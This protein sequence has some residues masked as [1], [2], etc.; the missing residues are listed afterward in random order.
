MIHKPLF[1]YNSSPSLFNE[2]TVKTDDIICSTKFPAFWIWLIA[3][4][5]CSP[6][7]SIPAVFSTL[8]LRNLSKLRVYTY[9]YILVD[10]LHKW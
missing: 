10:V 9:M 7:S 5:F 1:V 6:Y 3:H 4:S 8:T 2:F